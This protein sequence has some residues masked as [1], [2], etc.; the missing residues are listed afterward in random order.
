MPKTEEAELQIPDELLIP[1]GYEEWPE[2]YRPTRIKPNRLSFPSPFVEYPGYITL[3]LY[4]SASDYHTWWTKEGEGK[5]KED[6]WAFWHWET[7]HHLVKD[8]K[9]DNIETQELDEKGLELPDLR[10]AI[11]F[12]IITQPVIQEATNL[13]NWVEPSSDA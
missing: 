8:W 1:D 11:W 9:L 10:I 7:R 4:L 5:P 2:G 3:P 6:H 13:P 12:T